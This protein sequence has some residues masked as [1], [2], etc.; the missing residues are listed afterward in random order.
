M[1]CLYT[2]QC[3]YQGKCTTNGFNSLRIHKLKKL[4]KQLVQD[5][6]LS[7]I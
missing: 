6:R 3:N 4:Y 1:Q 5:L 7:W 2:G